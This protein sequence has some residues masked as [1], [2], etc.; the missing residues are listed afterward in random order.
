[1]TVHSNLQ[2]NP[3]N[4]RGLTPPSSQSKIKKMLASTV[5]FSTN[6]QTPA[7]RPH[8]TPSPT[9]E[10]RYEIPTGPAEINGR[11]FPQ[12]PTARLRPP[13]PTNSA[14]HHPTGGRQYQE[15][16][17]ASRPNWSAFHPRAPPR[18]PATHSDMS[19]RSRPG[20]ALDRATAAGRPGAP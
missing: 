12:D 5:Q 4:P 8:Q 14:P 10:E 20:M 9:G 11:P 18:Q 6:N 19:R 3:T 13:A 2:T 7:T 1:M 17:I 16:A 15:P